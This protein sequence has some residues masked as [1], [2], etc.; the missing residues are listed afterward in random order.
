MIKNRSDSFEKA[1]VG[2]MKNERRTQ[3]EATDS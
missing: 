1:D 3:T 2:G